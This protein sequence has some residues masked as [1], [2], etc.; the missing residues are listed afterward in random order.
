MG[1]NAECTWRCDGCD[2]VSIWKGLTIPKDWAELK[3][4]TVRGLSYDKNFYVCQ[5]CFA[6]LLQNRRTGPTW[7][8]KL[9]KAI[10]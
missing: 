3:L 4:R 7:F 5:M 9:K 10:T 8:Q 1:A 6:V 2:D